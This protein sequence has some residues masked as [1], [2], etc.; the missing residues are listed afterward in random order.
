[1]CYENPKNKITAVPAKE[2]EI[3]GATFKVTKWNKYINYSLETTV[4]VFWSPLMK[5]SWDPIVFHIRWKGQQLLQ[6]DNRYSLK[7][8]SLQ[9]GIGRVYLS[10]ITVFL[11]STWFYQCYQC[12]VTFLNLIKKKTLLLN[13]LPPFYIQIFKTT[14]LRL[15]R[16]TITSIAYREQYTLPL[17]FLNQLINLLANYFRFIQKFGFCKLFTMHILKKLLHE[18]EYTYQGFLFYL[19]VFVKFSQI[20][21]SILHFW[22]SFLHVKRFELSADE[23]A[24]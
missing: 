5:L 18:S 1:M 3:W 15:K 17:D 7:K 16:K 4:T 23:N 21:F 6:P 20:G 10:S 22:Y 12:T 24:T 13:F 19:F 14:K 11:I 8:W 2:E 9:W